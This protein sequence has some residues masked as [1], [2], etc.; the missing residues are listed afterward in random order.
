[1]TDTNQRIADLEARVESALAIDARFKAV[2]SEL[3][4]LKK[5]GVR[6]WL[7]A[8]APFATSLALLLVGYWLNDSVK[9]AMAREQLDLDYV[10]DMRDLIKD[11]DA[12]TTQPVADANAIGLAMYGKYA[13]LPL[14]QRLEGGDVANLAAEK[15]LV[16]VGSND[17]SAA[18]PKFAAIIDDKGRR[19]PWQTHKTIVKVMGQSACL[20]TIPDIAAY[21]VELTALGGDA[22]SLSKFAQRYSQPEGFDGE[23]IANLRK[24]IDTTLDILKSQ[25]PP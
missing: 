12:S 1:V 25:V 7:H 5:S 8:I 22:Q 15:G 13:I 17:P 14:V 21:K 11:F 3:A 9:A 20:K 23:S 10:K 2:D 16:L 6:G 18:C 24:Q 4:E 19:F